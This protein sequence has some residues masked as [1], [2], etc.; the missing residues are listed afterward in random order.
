MHATHLPASPTPAYV[1][2]VQTPRPIAM[3]GL[4]LSMALTSAASSTANVTLP[5]L[6]ES[7]DAH[8]GELQW[9]VT[10]YLIAITGTLLGIGILIHRLG[11][12]RLFF[13]G[14]VVF[15]GG[16][17]AIAVSPSLPSVALPLAPLRQG[18]SSHP[19]D[20]GR[21]LSSTSRLR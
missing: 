15:A 14:V 3:A 18:R 2:L 16:S 7:F 11:Q 4:G 20:G 9:V 12:R 13:L 21:S 19:A 17:L 5:T 10:A 1:R 6:A 8:F